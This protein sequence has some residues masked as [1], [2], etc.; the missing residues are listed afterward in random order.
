MKFSGQPRA[1]GVSNVATPSG[2]K[3]VP[4]F[5]PAIGQSVD[6]AAA[7]LGWCTLPRS[8]RGKRDDVVGAI[9]EE[10]M[11]YPCVKK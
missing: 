3:D 11:T 8:E 5:R 4:A 7:A 10:G 9:C 2:D 1:D 6:R